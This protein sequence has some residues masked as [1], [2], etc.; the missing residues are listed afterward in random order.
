MEIDP[1]ILQLRADINKYLSDVRSTTTQVERL[2]GS[3]EKRA[4]QL[5]REMRRST[6]SIGAGFKALSGSLAGYFTGRE[7]SGLLDSFTRLQNNLKVTG[8]EGDKLKATQDRLFA[9]AQKYGVELEGLSGLYSS[10]AQATKR[11]G[12][13]QEEVFT[14][15]D[16]V[17]AALKITGQ[18]SEK[19]AGSLLQLGQVFRGSKVQAEEFSSI[20]DGLYPLLEA[21]AAGSDRW[22]GSV[23]KLIN[24][25]K[26]S[27]VTSQEFFDAINRGSDV[28]EKKAA[29][30]T[31]TLS[32]GF[33]T[34]TNALTVYF[35][36]ADKANGV[37]AMVGEAMGALARNLETVIPAIALVATALGVKYVA[38]AVAA[39]TATVAKS[40]ADVRATQTAIALAAAQARLG[41]LM[42]SEAA[43]ANAAA[44]SVTRLSVAQGVAARGGAALLAAMGGTLGAAILA[45]GAA[46]YVASV[47]VDKLSEATGRY[48]DLERQGVTVREKATDVAQK[49]ATATGAAADAARKNAAASRDEAQALLTK[50]KAALVAA[51][52][53]A[54]AAAARAKSS[55]LAAPGQAAGTFRAIGAVFGVGP[56][57]ENARAKANL[58]AAESAAADAQAALD[59]F[60]T[61]K[62]PAPLGGGDGGKG[63]G[64]KKSGSTGPS[65][66]DIADRFNSELVSLAQQT[67]SAQQ[68]QARSAEEKAELELRSV[69]LA[70]I[71]TVAEVQ[72]DQD[73]SKA[74]K[75]RII[76]QVERL[77][78]EERAAIEYQKQ[79]QLEQEAQDLADERYRSEQDALRIQYDLAD[80]QGERKR[81]ALEMLDLEQRYQRSLLDAII[82]SE[83]ATDAVKRRAQVA[84]DGLNAI[85]AGDRERTTRQNETYAERYL[86]ELNRSPEQINEAIDGIKVDGLDALNDGL[87]D[88]VRGVKDLGDVF[89]SV[90]D[91][92]IADLLRIA[93][94]RS[95][96]GPLAN[97][98]FGGAS[99]FGGGGGA[100]ASSSGFNSSSLGLSSLAGGRAGGGY[101]EGGKLYR[102]N[103]GAK[104]EAFRPQGSGEI[105]PLGEMAAMRGGGAVSQHITIQVNAEGALLTTQV[106]RMVQAG[107]E[108]AAQIGVSGGAAEAERRI[109]SRS[110]R[111]IP[112]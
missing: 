23:D 24:D 28:L 47:R 86:R 46:F 76:L 45:L 105:I 64:T 63:G 103:E 50:A 60:A 87:V 68:S 26:A 59:A 70:R 38:G 94:Q 55:P 17:S 81:V 9:S 14:I 85:A 82:A 19:A 66:A 54:Q 20:V 110:R 2:L 73:Y 49:L 15:T 74:Q 111:T 62:V 5:E 30:A 107:M 53:E 108:Q 88:A 52:A 35:G 27:T 72:A 99:L 65:A 58:K 43:A 37:S 6:N 44:A 91:Q 8:L 41:P 16:S 71:R 42:L 112:R 3:Q 83:T 31:L 13:T 32:G 67:L 40:V 29:K 7:L 33:T 11:F 75:E 22:S 102:V 25:V 104:V 56:L 4:Q 109:M 106:Q 96:I 57:A 34:L 98:I 39:T 61:P 101:V 79:R 93:I 18:T 100:F 78:E 90:A 21:A 92:I 1:V 80:S 36:E 97:E 89:S 84:L 10:I 12:A 51:K 48:A 69:E 95:I 77:A